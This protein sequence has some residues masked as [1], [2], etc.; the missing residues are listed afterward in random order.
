MR[1]PDFNNLLK[2]LRRERP[3][4]PTLFDFFMNLPLYERVNGRGYPGGTELDYS[5]FVMEAFAKMG[6]D[7]LTTHGSNFGFPKRERRQKASLSLNEGAMITDRA[8]FERYPWP[9]PD[10]ADYSRL[11]TLRRYLP[12]GMKLVVYGPDGVLENVIRLVGYDNVCFMLYEDPELLGWI[13]DAVGSRLVR[14]YEIAGQA[15][16]V[17]AMIGNDDWGF[18]T[19]PFLSP[20]DLRKYVFPWHRR[21]V[22]TIHGCGMP[23]ILHS[24]GNMSALWEDVIA[25]GY[26]AKHSYEDAIA[27]VEQE[28]EKYAGRIA[29]LGGMDI[30]YVC[31]HPVAEIRRRA[32]A[33]LKRAADRG[34]YALGMGSAV[35]DYVPQDSFLAMIDVATGDGWL[36]EPA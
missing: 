10:A 15:D 20:A 26:D 25:L 23:A 4:R 17:G 9:D 33:M 6:Y 11:D 5:L 22:E 7:H 1:S 34:G 8:S 30:D 24:C 2:V 12:E 28:Y 21:I 31:A 19:Q 14:Y 35:P 36:L 32:G 29:V 3:E 18:K 13:F 16:S 27:P